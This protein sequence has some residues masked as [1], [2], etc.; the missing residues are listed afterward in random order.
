VKTVAS[1][2]VALLF[3]D[4]PNAYHYETLDILAEQRA[5][6]TFA[7][8]G[9]RI[10]GK[11]E[12]LR[13]MLAYGHAIANHSWSHPHLTAENVADEIARAQVAIRNAT[14]YTPC[15]F[16]PPHG[17]YGRDVVHAA[18]QQDL[19]TIDVQVNTRDWA[20]PGTEVIYHRVVDRVRRGAIVLLHP[21]EQTNAVLPRIV[22]H[23]RVRGYHLHTVPRLLGLTED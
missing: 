15:V 16:R 3:A 10:A 23:L 18:K 14:G 9:R 5:K 2:G 4:G 22:D 19:V 8:V 6:A 17:D 1:G 12:L 11:E 20:K 13:Q 21:S 7:V